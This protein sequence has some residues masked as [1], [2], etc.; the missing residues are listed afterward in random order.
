LLNKTKKDTR[1]NKHELFGKY[2]SQ[3]LQNNLQL[4]DYH[5]FLVDRDI[6]RVENDF[7]DANYNF[8]NLKNSLHI[9]YFQINTSGFCPT[10]ALFKNNSLYDQM[11][12]ANCPKYCYGIYLASNAENNSFLLGNTIY[13]ICEL[14]S[15]STNE[16][17][18]ITGR[19]DRV[20]YH[21]IN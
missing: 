21:K 13:G 4:E 15:L 3:I 5:R 11:Y 2:N 19:I 7:I 9:P 20:V 1:L 18:K 17:Q 14:N 6:L 10:H 12:V 8:S 16:L